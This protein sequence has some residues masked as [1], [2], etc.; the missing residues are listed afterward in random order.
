VYRDA[1]LIQ[2]LSDPKAVSLVDNVPRGT[3]SYAA[4]S[5]NTA[6]T[7]SALSQAVS[8]TKAAAPSIPSAPVI[9]QADLK[10]YTVTKGQGKFV[11]LP[12]GTA[13]ANTMCDSTQSVNGVYFMVP[14]ASVKWSSNS[15]TT[16]PVALCQ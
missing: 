11:L 16:T 4:K 6:G 12:I 2:T 9:T 3:Y 10:V 5:Y 8:V 14:V 7:R 13:P 1:T 15:R